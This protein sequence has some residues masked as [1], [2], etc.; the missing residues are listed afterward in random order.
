MFYWYFNHLS[1]RCF[2]G[3][4]M[5]HDLVSP[6]LMQT[7]VTDGLKFTCVTHQMNTLRL[8]VHDI[9]NDKYN[10][11]SHSETIPLYHK[12]DEEGNVSIF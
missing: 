2:V 12:I 11:Y 5:H 1:I 10:G 4:D 7:I 9:D 3:Y 6:I 8:F